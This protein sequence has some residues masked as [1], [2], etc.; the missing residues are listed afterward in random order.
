MAK[1]PERLR[2]VGLIC[3]ACLTTG[4]LTFLIKKHLL[5]DVCLGCYVM[6]RAGKSEFGPFQVPLLECTE[7][8]RSDFPYFVSWSQRFLHFAL[9]DSPCKQRR[10]A[11]SSLVH[12][13]QM[14]DVAEAA[15]R[16]LARS[17]WLTWV[18]YFSTNCRSSIAKSWISYPSQESQNYPRYSRFHAISALQA[19]GSP[20]LAG[21][22]VV[23]VTP[24]MY[25]IPR[26]RGL[27]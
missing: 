27:I 14:P 13:Q 21:F 23:R 18:F 26:F 1:T 17:P 24:K 22:G 12:S 11:G 6:P 20:W 10:N 2:R 9:S 8:S 25:I 19:A 3:L 5:A 7:P 15:D 4:L 16:S